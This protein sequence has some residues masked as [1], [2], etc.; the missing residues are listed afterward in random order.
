MPAQ[1]LI[2]GG[3]LGAGKTTLLLRAARQLTDQGYR[4]GLV[5]NDQGKNLV[6]TAL[7]TARAYPVTEVSGGCFCC[8]FPDLVKALTLLQEQVN[9]DIILAEPVGSCTDLISTTLRPLAIYYPNQFRVA[10]LSVLV[11]PHRDLS[12]FPA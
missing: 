7:V 12:I 3:F 5:T 1:V 10:P 2:G 4:V 11:D 9:P 8:N 6:D